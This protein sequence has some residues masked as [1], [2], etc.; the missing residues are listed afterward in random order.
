MV[1]VATFIYVR[2]LFCKSI[3]RGKNNII[4]FCFVCGRSI[5]TLNSAVKPFGLEIQGTISMHCRERG[6]HERGVSHARYLAHGN[7]K[8]VA[9]GRRRHKNNSKIVRNLEERKV[10]TK[11][12]SPEEGLTSVEDLIIEFSE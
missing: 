11:E 7:S 9:R 1:F 3:I 6:S 8:G 2:E 4:L 5:A 10:V 12:K